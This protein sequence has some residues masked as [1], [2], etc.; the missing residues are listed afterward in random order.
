MRGLS[1]GFFRKIDIQSLESLTS[2]FEFSDYKYY[3]VFKK[4]T[5][6][7]YI[8]QQV[9]D[10]LSDDKQS[11]V[12]VARMGKEIVGLI[13]LVKVFW[14]K[15]IFNIEMAE[16]KHIIVP[17]THKDKRDIIKDL[18]CFTFQICNEEGFC[19]LSCRVNTDNYSIIHS[20]EAN[21]FR[22][23]ETLVTYLFN[24]RKHIIPQLKSMCEI[25]S[26]NKGDMEGLSEMVKGAFPLSRF[27][28]DPNIP[29]DRIDRFYTTWVS[30]CCK[31]VLAEKVL[32]AERKGKPVGFLSYRLNK[33][34]ERLSGYKIV[35][36]GLSAVS[37]QGK[38]IYPTLMKAS[39]QDVVQLYDFGE[40]DTQINNY[41]V[42]KI[43]QRF[44]LDFVKSKYSFHKWLS[45]V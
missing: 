42:V 32:I 18:L 19:H 9:L 1:I 27:Y 12:I 13:S 6:H 25:R 15:E 24:K 3:G 37:V 2:C 11:W 7:K 44:G 17:R 41:E 4:E 14:G 28:V 34:L 8:F 22:V 30:E 31:G 38:G 45:T 20:L 10:L 29:D 16:I 33:E 43:W 21:G 39:M 26:F 40:F 36:Q 5:I 23:M 35:G